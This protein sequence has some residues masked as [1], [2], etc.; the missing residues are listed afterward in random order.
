VVKRYDEPFDFL[1]YLVTTIGQRPATSLAEAQAAAYVDGR[2]RRAGLNVAAETFY[3]PPNKGLLAPLLAIGGAGIALLMVW[4]PFAAFIL[5]VVFL[6][7]VLIDGFIRPLPAFTRFATS[8]NI[9]GNRACARHYPRWRVVLLA[10]LDSLLDARAATRADGG[11]SL[12]IGRV[13]AF[14]LLGVIALLG[15]TV[16]AIPWLYIQTLPALYLLV[17]LIRRQ[18]GQEATIGGSGALAVVL[19]VAERLTSLEH[20]EV[21]VAA[22]GATATGHFGVRDFLARYPFPPAETLFLS[23]ETI[24]TNNLICATREGML[25][26]HAAD[27]LLLRLATTVNA[28]EP[29]VAIQPATYPAHTSLAAPLHERRYRAMTLLSR[30][31]LPPSA[32]HDVLSRFDPH[33]LERTSR[34]LTAMIERLDEDA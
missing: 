14:L 1:R 18:P 13:V 7:V 29:L 23:L 10:P 20:V 11:R 30:G 19:T 6:I 5:A 4:L 3:A 9:I 32:K 25:K 24:V 33:T 12:V 28:E 26:Q 34:F 2:L 31:I 8:Q 15:M 27:A 22:V 17:S 21:W 16:P